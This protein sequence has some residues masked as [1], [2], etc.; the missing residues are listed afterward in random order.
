MVALVVIALMLLT[1]IVSWDDIVGNR[2]AWTVLCWFATLVVLAD[3]LNKVGLRRLVREDGGGLLA[4]YL[5]DRRHG[6]ARRAVLSRP[7][8][9]RESHRAYD[10]GV[11]GH[12]GGRCGGAGHADPDV[13]AAAG[14]LARHHGR[15]H[16]VC[17]WSGPCVFRER[18]P[19]ARR[20]L[21]ARPDL[22]ADLSRR[23]PA[24]RR[25]VAH[26]ARSV[27]F[28]FRGARAKARARTWKWRMRVKRR[29]TC[30]SVL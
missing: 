3:G 16:A 15:H 14:I 24:D 17:D 29:P 18:L 7:L 23:T 11:A 8:H 30:R 12:P 26:D 9:V 13:R 1:G 28:G 4:G 25:A 5:T 6:V 2:P 19:G 22:R 21:A 10:G 27:S 20:F